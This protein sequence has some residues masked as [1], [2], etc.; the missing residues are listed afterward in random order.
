MATLKD[1]EIKIINDI[2]LE[3]YNTDTRE[4]MEKRFL[5]SI[6]ALVP[7]KMSNFCVKTDRSTENLLDNEVI[8]V[9]AE[10]HIIPEFTK[11]VEASKNYLKNMFV[12]QTSFVCVDSDI[13]DDQIRQKTQFYKEFLEPQGTPYCAEIILLENGTNLGVINLFR[14][15][16]LGDF[17]EKEVFILDLFKDHL[18]AIISKY[19]TP[20]KITVPAFF[21]GAN[22]SLTKR[23]MEI[24]PMLISGFSNDEIAQELCI[25]LS[26][27][28]K[29]VYNIYRKYHVNSRSE[30]IKK[31]YQA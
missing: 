4:L 21:S 31:L 17:T 18:A 15:E 12:Y 3:L 30:L 16:D 2:I 27:T 26:T 13:L 7:Y 23:E 10:D 11:S 28:K 25:T 24:I 22:E 19:I 1:N 29:H 20:K 6:S 9:G 8:F 14:G 5:E